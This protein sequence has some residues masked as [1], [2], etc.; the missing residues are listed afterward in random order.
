MGHERLRRVADGDRLQADRGESAEHAGEKTRPIGAGAKAMPALDDYAIGPFLVATVANDSLKGLAIHATFCV[1][2]SR[3]A[4]SYAVQAV[5]MMVSYSS[6]KGNK[7]DTNV[8]VESGSLELR[9]LL[10]EEDDGWWS[11]QCL[12]YD[13]ATQ[14]KKLTDVPDAFCHAIMAYISLEEAG[15]FAL[16]RLGSAP[17]KFWD[18]YEQSGS[19]LELRMIRADVVEE[20]ERSFPVPHFRVAEGVA[21]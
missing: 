19:T 11:A 21:I 15:E 1:G 4:Y 2:S 9:V 16:D 20:S 14:A 7:R 5:N 13:I 12:E 6:R 10:I 3:T 17:Q 8:S 18:L